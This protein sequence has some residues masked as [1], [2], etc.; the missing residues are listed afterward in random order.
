M[1][2]G[3]DNFVRIDHDCR[4]SHQ[5]SYPDLPQGPSQCTL[6]VSDLLP[7]SHNLS[8][9]GREKW[10]VV[11]E[12]EPWCSQGPPGY[13]EREWEVEV[14]AYS[15]VDQQDMAQSEEA[16]SAAQRRDERRFWQASPAWEGAIG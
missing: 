4:E 3:G 13:K 15:A 16:S 14:T 5:Q 7:S 12:D 2:L 10:Q 9:H 8:H 11:V 1:G 6:P